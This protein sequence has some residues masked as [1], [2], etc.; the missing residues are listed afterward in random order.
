MKKIL[1]SVAAVALLFTTSCSDFLDRAPQ[2]KL[3]PSTFWQT[4]NDAY[5]A[6]TGV[7]NSLNSIYHNGHWTGNNC[8]MMDCFSDNYFDYFSWEGY[9]VLTSGN[10]KPTDTGFAGSLFTF[11]DIRACNEYLEMEGNVNWADTKKQAQYAAEAK[12][13]RANLYLYKSEWYGD[14]PLVLKTLTLEEAAEVTRAPQAEV[15]AQVIKDLQEAIPAL[16]DRLDQ[17]QGRISK[18][19]AQGL[20]MRTYLWHSQYAEAATQAKAILDYFNQKG[21]DL[22]PS[23]V[24]MFEQGKQ[25]S[26]DVIFDF[27]FVA[28]TDREWQYGAV[29]FVANG[30]HGGW[31][32]II[33]T[34]DLMDEFETLNGLAIDDP[35]NKMYDPEHPFLNRDPRLRAS[36][37]YPGQQYVGYEDSQTGCYNPM[38]KLNADGSNNDDYWQNANNATKSGLQLGKYFQSANITGGALQHFSLDFKVMRLA[39]I[40]LTLAE[41]DIEQGNLDEAATLINRVRKRAGMPEVA[42]DVKAS[43][44]KMRALVRRERRVELNGE[45]LRRFD[46]VRWQVDK[47]GNWVADGG[48]PYIVW[49]FQNKMAIEHLEGTI[50]NYKD[51]NGDWV[52]HVTGRVGKN[53]D[54]VCAYNVQNFR[55]FSERNIFWPVP[56]GTID[57]NPNIKQTVGY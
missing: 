10:L 53:P 34:V 56:Q 40:I 49:K 6:L 27:A 44:D 23:Y 12:V 52:A 9:T 35:A 2:D 42:A 18:Q 31:S 20:L 51:A 46:M 28:N 50:E 21:I 45:A 14:F 25:Y 36:M 7:Y 30:A 48:T 41:C 57:V 4:E 8:V 43:Q 29:P 55:T 24:G 13:V 33:P 37:L 22:N 26:E 3:S 11:N 39:E 47:D 5:L 38:P 16:P 17:S 19:F 1:Y 15:R 54:D 32:S